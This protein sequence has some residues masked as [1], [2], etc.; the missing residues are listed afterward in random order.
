MADRRRQNPRVDLPL[1]FSFF[2]L[3]VEVVLGGD[4]S[5]VRCRLLK[6][7]AHTTLV[8]QNIIRTTSLEKVVWEFSERALVLDLLYMLT[9]AEVESYL[10]HMPCARR[11]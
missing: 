2:G 8:M 1:P 10:P 3:E 5:Q 6:I 7:S 4:W 9:E 11:H